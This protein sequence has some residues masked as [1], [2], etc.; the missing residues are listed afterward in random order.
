MSFLA[1]DLL[2]A[3]EYSKASARFMFTGKLG[4]AELW[5]ENGEI[6]QIE[7][8]TIESLRKLLLQSPV[9]IWVRP[10]EAMSLQT[11]E[12]KSLNIKDLAFEAAAH[13]DSGKE[14]MMSSRNQKAD[15]SGSKEM[16]L[17][18]Q[19]LQEPTAILKEQSQTKTASYP[20]LSIANNIEEK[21]KSTSKSSS[22]STK[23]SPPKRAIHFTAGH[24]EKKLIGRN[25]ECNVVI[26]DKQISRQHCEIQY[27]GTTLRV[28]DLDSTNGTFLNGVKVTKETEAKPDDLLKM[29]GALFN[30]SVH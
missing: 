15:S 26:I 28:T 25:N 10:L 5:I 2:Q 22:D 17:A 23:T 14:E 12:N 21:E 7:G 11:T 13:H 24:P 20:L 4:H 9:E 3:L 16:S 8:C 30:L 19:I 18:H 29:G 6:Q 27:D 1:L